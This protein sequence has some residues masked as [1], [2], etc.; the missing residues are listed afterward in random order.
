MTLFVQFCYVFGIPLE[1][2]TASHFGAFTEFLVQ[3]SVHPNTI[4]NYF[5]AI[6]AL[7]S[8]WEKWEVVRLLNSQTWTRTHKA[9]ANSVRPTIPDKTAVSIEHLYMMLDVCSQDASLFALAVA[10]SL[11]F[12]G[13]LRIS[14]IAPDSASSFDATRHSTVQDIVPTHGGLL[15][16]VRWSKTR[17]HSTPAQYIPIPSLGD[18]PICPAAAW[19]RYC[20]TVTPACLRD[21][22]PLLCGSESTMHTAT[23]TSRLR[24]QL[25]DVT[26]LAGLGDEGYTPHSFRRGGASFSH[27]AGVSIE[28][29]K[30]HGTWTSDAVR[31]YLLASPP[32][33]SPV[34]AAF[35]KAL[36]Q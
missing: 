25:R 19:F 4:K 33:A 3:D 18:S 5:S 17:Q 16:R 22:A 23:T 27:H 35:Q 1:A 6:K 24:R 29:I 13:Y 34:V 12:F 32:F 14:N 11:A 30:I 20:R 10:I 8:W 36:R 28:A 26:T 21:N 2:P 7:F 31:G 9:I 15:F